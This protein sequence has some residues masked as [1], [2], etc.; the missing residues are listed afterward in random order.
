VSILDNPYVVLRQSNGKYLFLSE[1]ADVV[2]NSK[3]ELVTT[4]GQN[5]FDNNIQSIL[6]ETK[7]G[8]K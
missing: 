3:C 8:N 6:R 1:K 7:N 4:Y 2:V 5:Y